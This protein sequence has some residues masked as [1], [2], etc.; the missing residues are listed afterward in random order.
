MIDESFENFMRY[1]SQ[2]FRSMFPD[3][4]PN[5]Q[6]DDG[7]SIEFDELPGRVEQTR[8]SNDVITG[9]EDQGVKEPFVETYKDDEGNFTILIDLPG[10]VD[11]EYTIT[12]AGDTL[13]LDAMNDKHHYKTSI[14]VEIKIDENSIEPRLNNG[15]LE[16]RARPR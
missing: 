2:Y 1:I 12:V 11:G 7:T 16:I 10:I 3:E 9:L 6:D 13:L 8:E 14:P 5:G 4:S 15:L